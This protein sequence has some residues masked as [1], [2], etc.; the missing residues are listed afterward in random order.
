MLSFNSDKKDR[1]SVQQVMNSQLG[2]NLNLNLNLKYIQDENKEQITTERKKRKIQT[3]PYKILDAPGLADDFYLNLL[4]WSPDDKLTIGLERSIYVWKAS[5]SEVQKV[6]ENANGAEGAQ[7]NVCSVQWSRRQN[8]WLAY[9]DGEGVVRLLDVCKHR[10][11]AEF[12]S[13]Q[14][15]VGSLAF[16]GSLLA[17]GSRDRSVLVRDLRESQA[18][19]VHKHT[20]H[21]QEICGLKWSFD[22]LQLASGGNDNKLVLFSSVK[23]QEL[24]SFTQHQAAVKAIAWSPH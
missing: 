8:E 9:G 17:S 1:L 4:D 22:G 5:G 15:R 19:S 10:L 12:P 13:H 6:V 21:K 7:N 3:K 20:S 16:N 23:N 24:H 2:S 11:V 18:H 14:A